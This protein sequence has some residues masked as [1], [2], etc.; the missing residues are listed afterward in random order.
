M[1]WKPEPEVLVPFESGADKRYAAQVEVLR[2]AP[3]ADKDA[4]LTASSE[5][6][7][8]PHLRGR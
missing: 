6:A 4:P 7:P 8:W 3:R 2:R 1:T 5:Y